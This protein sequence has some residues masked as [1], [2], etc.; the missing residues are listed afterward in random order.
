[1]PYD[2]FDGYAI[3]Y[4]TWYDTE[5]G[6]AI[7]AM[8]VDCLKPLL[9]KYDRP[10]VEVGAGSGRFARALGI[11]YG[12][13]PALSLANIARN[14]DIKISAAVAEKLPFP[15]SMFGG[16]LIAFALCFLDNPQKALQESWRVLRPEGGL[17]LGLILRDSPWA[18]Y[19]TKKGKEG[20]PIYSK[21]RFFSKDEVEDLLKH[22]GFKVLEYSSTLYQ[23]PGQRSYQYETP[24]PGYNQSAGFVAV[25]SQKEKIQESPTSV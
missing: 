8:E 20:H 3:E 6:K 7:F 10:Y 25:K 22:S 23:P 4:D 15:D 21:A 19:Y 2:V 16:V 24:F 13:E 5:A 12:V 17:V 18:E 1:M 11:E 14:R 9:H